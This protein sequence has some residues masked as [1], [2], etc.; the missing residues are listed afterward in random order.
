MGIFYYGTDNLSIKTYESKLMNFPTIDYL[1]AK[2]DFGAGIVRE[3]EYHVLRSGSLFYIVLDTS[4]TSGD[5]TPVCIEKQF[6]FRP[7]H[8]IEDPG[9]RTGYRVFPDIICASKAE[10]VQVSS[11]RQDLI[12][13]SE[14]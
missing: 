4:H 9:K 2:I 6:F 7:L 11:L 13:E 3:S 1:V 5:V 10:W 14:Q 12:Q 8:T